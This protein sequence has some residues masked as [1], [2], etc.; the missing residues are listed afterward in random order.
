M[1]QGNL[2]LEFTNV[3]P[4]SFNKFRIESINNFLDSRM[5]SETIRYVVAKGEA[6][7]QF[8]QQLPN[9]TIVDIW[10]KKG[11]KKYHAGW[12]WYGIIYDK[13]HHLHLILRPQYRRQGIG[14]QV[15][16]YIDEKAIEAGHTQIWGHVFWEN[17]V[18]VTSHLANGFK[19]YSVTLLREI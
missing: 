6:D 14:R 11:G 10:V 15:R 1:T 4:K 5:K 16:T 18:A 13:F 3:S 8:R 12:T 9:T 7:A 17:Q 2:D 19:P